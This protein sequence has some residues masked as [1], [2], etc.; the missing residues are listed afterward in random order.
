M[1][2]QPG[3]G[4]RRG[5]RDAPA[6]PDPDEPGPTT[7]R[8]LADLATW[9]SLA[10]AGLGL[11]LL[12]VRAGARVGTAAAP[13]LGRY[14]LALDPATVLAP[15]I[16]AAVLLAAASGVHERLRWRGLLLAGYLAAA[17]WALALVAVDGGAGLA[18]GLAGPAEYLVDA[19]AA[20]ADPGGFLASF[21]RHGP[22]LTAAT[23]GHPPLPVLALAAAG[24]L[25]LHRP[26]ALGVA[27]TLVG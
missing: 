25:G 14:A 1:P 9:L 23:R 5:G 15:T 10:A 27:V 22:E 7:R 19:P 26:V 12:A 18:R 8:E 11:T 13:F 6:L 21:V 17:G 20:A 16:A 4:S 2:S 24:R 3:A